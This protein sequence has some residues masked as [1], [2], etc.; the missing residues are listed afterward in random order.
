MFAK[1]PKYWEVPLK[2]HD[3]SAIIHIKKDKKFGANACVHNKQ[4]SSDMP[5]LEHGYWQKMNTV[6]KIEASIV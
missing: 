2:I 4:E 6:F 1:F 5:F 3:Y